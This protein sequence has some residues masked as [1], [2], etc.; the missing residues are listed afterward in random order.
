MAPTVLMN[1]AAT[2]VASVTGLL[3]NATALLAISGIG[4]CVAPG[5]WS[6]PGVVEVSLYN[7]T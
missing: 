4:E 6:G 3:G 2:T 1:A 7:C 5:S